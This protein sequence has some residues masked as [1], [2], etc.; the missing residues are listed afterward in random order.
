MVKKPPARSAAQKQQAK[1]AK[2]EEKMKAKNEK[3][4]EGALRKYE[5]NSVE[6]DLAFIQSSLAETP[7]FVAP[8]ARL[9]RQGAL[10][11]L[12][13]LN[14]AQPEQPDSQEGEKWR[15]KARKLLELPVPVMVSMLS[16]PEVHLSTEEQ[17]EEALVKHLFGVQFWITEDTPL[18]TH[19]NIRYI[20]TLEKFAQKRVED[21]GFTPLLSAG[22]D[23]WSDSMPVWKLEGNSLHFLLTGEASALPT[24]PGGGEWELSDPLCPAC[25]AEAPVE[26]WNTQCRGLFPAVAKICPEAKWKY[27]LDE[28]DVKA[29]AS[30]TLVLQGTSPAK[31]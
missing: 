11:A 2:K 15:G 31:S 29:A 12:L 13:R 4:L 14:T 10:N 20:A 5:Q 8:L 19:P 16:A 28:I 7:A 26:V 30:A 9:M 27:V 21:L 17:N 23:H 24:L 3:A 25:V 1:A 6:T 22:K 18:P